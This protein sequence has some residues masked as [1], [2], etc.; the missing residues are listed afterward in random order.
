M[1][2]KGTGMFI[3]KCEGALTLRSYAT[4]DL[5]T[6]A[7]GIPEGTVVFDSTTKQIKYMSG[8]AYVALTGA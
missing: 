2:I 8:A 3:D 1:T 4:S 5:P 6:A 7:S